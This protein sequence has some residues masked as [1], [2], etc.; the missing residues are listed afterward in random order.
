MTISHQQQPFT[1]VTLRV[2]PTLGS[3]RLNN[4]P[5]RLVYTCGLRLSAVHVY[6]SIGVSVG[7]HIFT[8]YLLSPKTSTHDVIEEHTWQS[9]IHRLNTRVNPLTPAVATRVGLLQL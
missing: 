7:L 1:P 2:I 3:C 5:Q 8:D 6:N 9:T 4:A